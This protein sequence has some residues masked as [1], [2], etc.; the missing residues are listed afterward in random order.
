M[1]TYSKESQPPSVYEQIGG[2]Q[3]VKKLVDEFYDVMDS[4]DEAKIV[5]SLHAKSLRVSRAKLFKF[6]SGWMGGPQLYIEEYGHPRLRRRHMPFAIGEV[7]RDQWMLCMT[8]A[9]KN[10]QLPTELQEHL[11]KL[12]Y[13]IADFM[14]NKDD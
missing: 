12:F 3:E 9:M 11:T 14:R 13:N 8:I 1:N 5:R 10:R 4:I 2:E 6:L 7:E